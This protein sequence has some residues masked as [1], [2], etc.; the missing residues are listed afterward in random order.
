[1]MLLTK[2]LKSK[3]TLT[4]ARATICGL[5]ALKNSQYIKEKRSINEEQLWQ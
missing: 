3:N 1:M 2:S 5:N 4:V